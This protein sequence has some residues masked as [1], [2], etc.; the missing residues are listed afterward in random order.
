MKSPVGSIWYFCEVL[1]LP[2]VHIKSCHHFGATIQANK[3]KLLSYYSHP[4]QHCRNTPPENITL[5]FSSSCPC[6]S[7]NDFSQFHP[8]N[9][10]NKYQCTLN[11]LIHLSIHRRDQGFSQRRGGE[12]LSPSSAGFISKYIAATCHVLKKACITIPQCQRD[13]DMA[14][15]P[16]HLD[17]HSSH[18]QQVALLVLFMSLQ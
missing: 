8:F 9:C 13:V 1:L 11:S 14:W 7:E 15:V 18:S 12:S 10:N 3:V 2:D 16:T 5:V 17:A 6:L 4:K